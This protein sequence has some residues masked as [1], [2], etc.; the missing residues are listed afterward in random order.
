MA[1]KMDRTRKFLGLP[2]V[3][4]AGILAVLAAPLPGLAGC[5]ERATAPDPRASDAPMERPARA[6]EAVAALRTQLQ[7]ALVEALGES[8]EAAIDACRVEAPRIAERVSAAGVEVGRTSHRP[9]NPRNA[10]EAWMIPLLDAYRA[11]PA[12]GDAWRAVDL[13]PRGTGYVEPIYLQP[14]CA[15]CHGEV[16]ETSLLQRIRAHYPDDEAV[17]FRVGEFRGIFWAVVPRNAQP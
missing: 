12:P 6:V 9:R 17:G 13:G 10:P 2:G 11:N 15:A 7:A 1:T 14:L 3:R 8:Q 5:G 16:V 4:L